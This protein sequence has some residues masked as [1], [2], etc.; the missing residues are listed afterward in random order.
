MSNKHT[1]QILGLQRSGT[2]FIEQLL[3]ENYSSENKVVILNKWQQSDGIWKHAYD[4]DP[5][6]SEIA[7]KNREGLYRRL[8]F[9]RSKSDSKIKLT[10]TNLLDV[11]RPEIVSKNYIWIHKHPYS[12]LESITNKPLDI[13]K[14][15]IWVKEEN[16]NQ[17]SEFVFFNSNRRGLDTLKLC[18]L[19]KEHTLYWFSVFKR[20]HMLNYKR[21]TY[22][23]L[24][25][26]PED[27]RRHLDEIS[28]Q[29]NFPLKNGEIIIPNKV[30]Q[31]STWDSKSH[32]KYTKI[33]ISKF[34]WEQIQKFNQIITKSVFDQLGYK[35]ITSHEEYLHHKVAT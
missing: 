17:D 30:S 19:Y 20:K 32:S 7:Q 25:K 35:M 24:I 11:S 16:K 31:S 27:T 12:W 10:G 9:N 21:I 14:T 4:V 33:K 15:Y 5:E 3:K 13:L 29:F 34:S 1:F 2:N 6:D 23:K 26:T 28:E 22:E 18:E 8:Q